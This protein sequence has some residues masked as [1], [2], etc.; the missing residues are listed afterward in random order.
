MITYS[1]Y[2]DSDGSFVVLK[3]IVILGEKEMFEAKMVKASF[4]K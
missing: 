2:A 1:K 4:S 3:G